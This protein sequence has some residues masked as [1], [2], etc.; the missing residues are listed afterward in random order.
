[1]SDDQII[2]AGWTAKVTEAAPDVTAYA[3]TG[4]HSPNLTQPDETAA[5][6]RTIFAAAER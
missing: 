3:M 5:L 4:P 1:M 6:L 2:E